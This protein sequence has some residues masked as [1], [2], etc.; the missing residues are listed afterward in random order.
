MTKLRTLTFTLST[1]L[2]T[3]LLACNLHAQPVTLSAICDDCVVERFANCGGFLEGATFDRNGRLWVVDLL[4]GNIL[5]VSDT[6]QCTVE[7]NT[8]GQP[9]GAKHHRDGRLFI[10]DKAKG[11]LAFDP[12]TK[13]LDTIV[14]M[15]RAELI[16]GF[17]DLVFDDNGGFYFTE[18]Y[19]SGTLNPVGRVFYMPPDGNNATLQVVADTLA[20]PNGIALSPNGNNLYIGEYARKRIISMPSLASRDVFDTSYV[21]ANT[22]GGI[23]PDGMA[24]DEVG[25]IYQAIF[26]GGQ[27]SVFSPAG[28][29]IG[30]IWLPAGAGAATTNVAFDGNWLYI[31]ESSEGVIW[32]VRTNHAGL[33]LY[34]QR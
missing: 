15:Y 17:N 9:N 19:G 29:E 7:A 20:F 34:H 11:I 16:R 6:G 5:S 13:T 12:E 33:K 22:E 10:A 24:V 4:S 27:V 8:G 25:N 28:Y 2:F 18:P 26:Q 32:R 30:K 31:T 3:L 21:K 14:N 23:G 1:M